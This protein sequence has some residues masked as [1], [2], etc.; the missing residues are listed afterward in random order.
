MEKQ[1]SQIEVDDLVILIL[2]APSRSKISQGKIDGI[3]RLEKLIF[4]LQKETS[5]SKKITEDPE[6]IAYNFGPYSKKVYQAVDLLKLAG[7]IIESEEISNSVEDIWETEE[8][9][10]EDVANQYITRKF[11]L[12]DKGFRYYQ[13][14]V[15]ELSKH[16][17][18]ILKE[19]KNKF[20]FL[21]LRQLVRYVYL[22][23]PEMTEKSLIRNEILDK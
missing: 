5:I 12:T 8:I 19:F 7:L 9:N 6:F 4:L 21:P 22:R 1:I 15:D 20:A 13:A 14:L 11:I 2:G 3:T 16:D 18:Q 23:Y 17:I 10:G